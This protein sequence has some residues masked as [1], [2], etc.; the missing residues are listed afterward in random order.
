MRE[1]LDDFYSEAVVAEENVSD[2]GNKNV[3]WLHPLGGIV[4]T[5]RQPLD[6]FR[7]EEKTVAGTSW[8][9]RAAW[10]VIQYNGD[11]KL[12]FKVLFNSLNGCSLSRQ[13]KIE[14]IAAR[15]R[16]EL[17]AMSRLDKAS[18]DMQLLDLRSPL[19]QQPAVVVHWEPGRCECSSRI[20]PCIRMNCS[21]PRDSVRS[22]NRL[23]RSSD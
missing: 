21:L 11:V 17:D 22:N 5:L 3:E 12:T 15:F 13:C 9:Y 20:M 18:A 19:E 14:N 8:S 2:P 23:A 6:F 16:C 10:I 1:A 4:R 7:R